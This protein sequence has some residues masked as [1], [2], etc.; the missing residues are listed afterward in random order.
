MRVGGYGFRL[1]GADTTDRFQDCRMNGIGVSVDR[2]FSEHVFV[3]GGADIYFA[4]TFPEGAS[5][6]GDTM[7]RVSGLMSAAA[8]LRMF[9]KSRINAYAQLGIGVEMTKV[10]VPSGDQVLEDSFVMPHG[11]IGFGTDVRL[12]KRLRIGASVRTHV[13]GHFVH[14]HEQEHDGVAV[15]LNGHAADELSPQPE[16]AAQG[17]F[18][19]KYAL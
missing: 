12:G 1:P 10:T 17:Q 7:D 3:E 15:D 2:S 16:I 6:E 9:P 8:G 19:L 18:Y 4:D 14:G 5:H 11:F 13:M